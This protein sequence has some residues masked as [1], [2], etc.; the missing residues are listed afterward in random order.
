MARPVP[1][2]WTHAATCRGESLEP[3]MTP[4]V[5][6]PVAISLEEAAARLNLSRSTLYRLIRTDELRTFKARRRRLIRI[7]ELTRFAARQER[8]SN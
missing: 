6:V 7:E 8:A 2:Q 4:A 1:A 5:S 3:S